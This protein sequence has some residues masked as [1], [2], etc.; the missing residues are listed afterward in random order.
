MRR[1]ITCAIPL[2]CAAVVVVAGCSSAPSTKSDVCGAF[3]DVGTQ[4][5]QGNGLGNPLF[6]KIGELAG[7]AGRYEG[8]ADL[9]S[10]ASSLHDL[11][12][13]HSVSGLDLMEATQNI[14]SLCGHTFGANAMTGGEGY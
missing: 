8:S 1:A 4:L 13:A 2:G 3:D 6:H 14:G 7:A 9:S 10:D 5:V 12:D 11:A